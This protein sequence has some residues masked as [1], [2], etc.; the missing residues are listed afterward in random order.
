MTLG[1][2]AVYFNMNRDYL[3][4]L[5]KSETKTSFRTYMN[6]LRIKKSKEL[7]IADNRKITDIAFKVGYRSLEHFNR[8]FRKSENTTPTE[9]K[10]L[11]IKEKGGERREV[12]AIT[13]YVY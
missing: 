9:F 5:F 8:I 4:K 13:S 10:S 6:R 3:G 2:T 12:T 7:L 1:L 11:I